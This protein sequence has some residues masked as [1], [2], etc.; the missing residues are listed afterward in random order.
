MAFSG[1]FNELWGDIAFQEFLATAGMA[2]VL[3][4]NYDRTITRKGDTVNVNF[5]DPATLTI[6]TSWESGNADNDF[7]NVVQVLVDQDPAVQVEINSIDTLRTNADLMRETAIAAGTALANDTDKVIISTVSG[8]ETSVAVTSY[9]TLM[10]ARETL[11][12]NGVRID[13]RKVFYFA[14]PGQAKALLQDTD[15]QNARVNFDPSNALVSGQ[16]GVIGGIN[17][18]EQ[19]AVAGGGILFHSDA[20][21]FVSQKTVEFEFDSML[22][23][24][25]KRGTVLGAFLLYGVK[26][27]SSKG[28]LHISDS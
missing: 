21:A 4:R 23:G 18:V 7:G 8:S 17:V 1:I 3:N 12:T 24:Q 20:L 11:S 19:A 28:V 25:K 15:I 16:I 14:S 9:D 22:G 5:F 27:L 2:S 13:P 26:T 10:D 6:Q